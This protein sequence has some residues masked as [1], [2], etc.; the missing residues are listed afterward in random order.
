[1]YISLSY[2]IIFIYKLCKSSILYSWREQNSCQIITNIFEHLLSAK[3]R[4]WWFIHIISLISLQW[5]LIV[6]TVRILILQLRKLRVW[7]KVKTFWRPPSSVLGKLLALRLFHSSPDWLQTALPL[8]I[9]PCSLCSLEFRKSSINACWLDGLM[10]EW[11]NDVPATFT[12]ILRIVLLGHMH[13]VLRSGEG[14]R[15]TG[16]LINSHKLPFPTATSKEPWRRN[17]PA[18]ED[19][20]ASS[21]TQERM[22]FQQRC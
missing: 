20:E 6:D 1:M 19:E 7:Q 17:W 4:S 18:K 8:R 13:P 22:C 14:W 21:F 5:P 9:V 11:V 12:V 3:P 16:L 10:R 2:V 15:R